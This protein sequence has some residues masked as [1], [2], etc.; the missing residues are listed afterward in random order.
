[1]ALAGVAAPGL[2]DAGFAEA[3]GGAPAAGVAKPPPR[4]HPRGE[5]EH[6]PRDQK[7]IALTFDA[8]SGP[9][10]GQ[11]DTAVLQALEAAHVPATVFV[12]GVWAE[13]DPERVKALLGDPLIELGTHAYHHPHLTNLSDAG[14][15]RELAD[16]VEVVRRQAGRTPTLFRAPYGEADRR[17]VRIATELR[18]T[19]IG[20][21]LASGDPDPKFVKRRLTRGVLAGARGGS[22]VVMHINGHGRHTAEALPDIVDGL[23][24]KGY[25]L[26]TVSQLLGR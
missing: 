17:V 18:L 20:F 16:A 26:V 22:I 5:I 23:R 10:P 14:L 21:D 25:E 2:G 15:R 7:R 1:V 24:K 12:G 3:D 13:Q 8:C 4:L 9:P 11:L 19:V 6:G